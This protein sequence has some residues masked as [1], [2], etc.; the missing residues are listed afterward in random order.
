MS[1]TLL[2]LICLGGC[3]AAARAQQKPAEEAA[4]TSMVSGRVFCADTNAPARMA[5]VSL[6]PADAVDAFNPEKGESMATQAEAVQTL[7]D[8]SFVI[9]RVAPG[10]Y[11]VIASLPGYVSPLSSLMKPEADGALPPEPISKRAAKLV[12]RVM[13][14]ANL[15]AVVNISL[16][17]GAA[18]SGTVQYDDGSPA[19][20]LGVGILVRWKDQWVDLPST[21]FERVSHYATTDDQGGYRISGL[22]AK[23]YMVQVTLNLTKSTFHS[24]GQHGSGQSSSTVFSLPV[25]SGNK[26]R[27]KDGERFT[28]KAGEERRGEDI[29]IPISKLHT[30]RGNILAKRDGHVINRGFVTLLNADDKS[31]AGYTEVA[32]EDESFQFGFV[33]EGDYILQVGFAADTEWFETP[34]PPHVNPPT[35]EDYRTLR[36]YGQADLPIHVEGDVSGVTVNVPDA[37][38]Q[39][40]QPNQ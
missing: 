37:P 25:Y 33:P 35:R 32:R 30:V 16:E 7:L 15:P 6:Q 1:R 26:T 40:G 31:Q 22:P 2:L 12:P 27:T 3:A 39:P 18:V 21:P 23:Q 4:G 38:G 5:T 19:S 10:A 14:R 8:G 29:Q 28:L 17:R 13:V 24:D 11:Y 9:P 34:N 36:S 20:G